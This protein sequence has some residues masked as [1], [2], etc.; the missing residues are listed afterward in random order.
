ML[1]MNWVKNMLLKVRNYKNEFIT[2]TS[3]LFIITLVV[4]ILGLLREILIAAF[5]GMSNETDAF[6]MALL[7]TTILTGVAGVGI[8]S[9]LI[10][11][12]SSNE[13]EYNQHKEN[14]I[15]TRIALYILFIFTTLSLG[16]YF[17]AD[18]VFVV[19]APGF[20]KETIDLTLKIFQIAFLRID[21]VVLLSLATQLLNKRQKFYSPMIASSIGTI[22][23]TL[24]LFIAQ[25]NANVFDLMK[26]T[27]FSD[28][29][30]LL[31]LIPPLVSSGYKPSFVNKFTGSAVKSF[32]LLSIPVIIS[33]GVQQ[34]GFF[35]NRGFASK[36]ETGSITALAY[37]T[38]II[39]MINMSLSLSISSV[40]YPKLAK[41]VY[42]RNNFESKRILED[43]YFLA[44]LFLAPAMAGILLLSKDI[45]KAIF[46]RGVF[47]EQNAL[48][49]SNALSGLAFGIIPYALYEFSIR[50]YYSLK[51]KAIPL[52]AT[53]V[54]FI[55]IIPLSYVLG[56]WWRLY[57]ISLAFSLTQL[58]MASFVLYKIRNTRLKIL[59]WNL[60]KK[61]IKIA[62]AVIIMSI[63]LHWLNIF[64]SNSLINLLVVLGIKILLSITV[65]FFVIVILFG[66][67][68]SIGNIKGIS[69]V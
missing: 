62:V 40:M 6:N 43:S 9:S 10:P 25:G 39:M 20:D 5:I 7:A 48:M 55:S 60:Y 45:S 63:N 19:L 52:I 15:F 1:T 65:Y 68:N 57:G 16:I 4:K 41:S 13:V 17:F 44:I 47:T 23:V 36:L 49:T 69:N 51:E 58:I 11:I 2:T 3:I 59:D 14:T 67:N 66:F 33:Y 21:I 26:V 56:Q 30:Q 27:L 35:I 31:Y 46:L 42:D 64:F 38:S 50:Y 24:Y 22:F 8:S 12:L 34:V 18:L 54:G 37:A 29:V 53:T 61:L 32:F 28:I